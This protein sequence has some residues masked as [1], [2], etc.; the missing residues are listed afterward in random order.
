MGS[1]ETSREPKSAGNGTSFN[2]APMERLKYKQTGNKPDPYVVRA[3]A[4][5]QNKLKSKMVQIN[6]GRVN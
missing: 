2:A 3:M 6:G 5:A 1:M 4:R